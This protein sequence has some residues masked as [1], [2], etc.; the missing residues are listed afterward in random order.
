MR[1][2]ITVMAQ[3]DPLV[4]DIE[5]NAVRAVE[6]V[7]EASIEHHADVV[8]FPELFLVGYSPEDLLLREALEARVS[9]ARALMASRMVPGVLVVIGYPG[10]RGSQLYNLAG[11]LRD[12]EWIAEYA[13]QALP[14]YGVFDERRYFTAGDALCVIEHQ[15]VRLG[16]SICEDLWLTE[17]AAGYAG[18]VDL[19]LSLN[20][21]PWHLGKLDERIAVITQRARAIST[22]IAY[23][24]QVGGQDDLVFD[25]ASF[26]LDSDGR[27]QVQAPAWEEGLMP[28]RLVD[29]GSGW[30]LAPGERARIAQDEESLYCALVVGLREYVRK[31]GFAGVVLG[32]SGGIDSALSLAVAVD[33]L[34]PERVRAVMMPYRYTADMSRDDA[35]TQAHGL[36]VAFEELPIGAAVEALD[37]ILGESFASLDPPSAQDVTEQNL[38]ARVRGTL[39]MA[40]ANRRGLMV[41][42]TGNKSEMAVGYA[43]LYGDMVGGYSVLKDLYKTQVY[44]LARWRNAQGEHGAPVI[45]PR[46]IERAPSAELA[47]G[48][49]DSDSLPDYP[50][51]DAILM[52]YIEQDHSLEAIVAEGFEREAVERVV[53]LV[54]R[55]EFK[56]RQSA[57]G[58]RVS[59]RA[60]GRERRYP[61]VNGWKPGD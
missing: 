48:Q 46:V 41:L 32:L 56:R 45:P 42:T 36:G 4:G 8:V 40:L 25:G 5:G 38:Q 39:L 12:G 7:R 22:P 44:G 59:K 21:S 57:P 20:C 13:K 51:L 26:A 58:V 17:P 61:I 11:A 53:A 14:N 16:L 29:E 60:F 50:T 33:A 15:G 52:R 55:N 28:L 34:G 23:V 1:Q 35:A 47:E 27:I 2:L 6:A 30:Q 31:S 3:C 9:K 43:T 54:D 18:Q 24:H 49:L 37:A 19:L 10:L